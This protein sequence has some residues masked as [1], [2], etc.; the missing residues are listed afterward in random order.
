[1]GKYFNDC[2]NPADLDTRYQEI[3][4]VFDLDNMDQGNLFKVEVEDEYH[5]QKASLAPI[6]GSSSTERD[7]YSMEEIIEIIRSLKLQAELVGCWLW[8]TGKDTHDHRQALKELGF[9]Y[10]PSKRSW[11][12]REYANRSSNTNPFTMEAIKEKFGARE[13]F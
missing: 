10:S 6:N 4:R 11:Y 8:L 5:T 7:N 13:L 12:W 1:M 9:R 2:K 3:K